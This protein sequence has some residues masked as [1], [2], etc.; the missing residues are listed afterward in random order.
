[1]SRSRVY[2]GNIT[3]RLIR[4]EP[5]AA[6]HKAACG[7]WRPGKGQ[8]RVPGWPEPTRMP[9]HG[10]SQLAPELPMCL[11]VMPSLFFF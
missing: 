2:Q 8:H 5:Q 1:M 11:L 3:D 7:R 4:S 10:D 9:S 6:G